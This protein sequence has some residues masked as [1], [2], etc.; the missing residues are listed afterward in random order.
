MSACTASS[1][2]YRDE[3]PAYVAGGYYEEGKG[4]AELAEEMAGY[5]A[6]GARAVK[7]K[8][9]ALPLGEDMERVKAV[10]V[11]VG[12]RVD[13]LV[14]ANGAYTTPA[15][16]SMA[17]LLAGQGVYWFEEPLSPDNIAG[18]RLL[19][20]DG[21]VPIAH[22]ENEY[23]R[24]G[25]R[26]LVSAGAADILNPDAQVLGGV[27]EFRRVASLAAAHEVPFAPHGNQE[28]H[29]HL[30]AGLPGGLLLEYYNENVVGLQVE[31][32]ANR[33]TLNP[34]GTVSPSSAPGLGVVLDE[35]LLEEAPGTFF[36]RRLSS[37]PLGAHQGAN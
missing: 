4:L 37:R 33:L 29:A 30:V 2:A 22:G 20:Q 1:A 35:D 12:D 26:D 14:D 15:A 19:V 28:I 11:A 31:M 6:K 23:T 8:V 36:R 3:I 32:V 16:R 25:F 24:C 18:Y 7:M 27:T 9:G 13:L 5:L 21:C 34:D 10:R 17:K